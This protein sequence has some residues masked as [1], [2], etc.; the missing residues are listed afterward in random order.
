MNRPKPLVEFVKFPR[1]PHFTFSHKTDRDDLVLS[2]EASEKMFSLEVIVQEKTDGANIGLSFDREASLRIQNR[3]EYVDPKNSLFKKLGD[4]VKLHESQL[5]DV[6]E[7]DK[8]ILFGEWLYYQHS[9][10]YGNL[11]SFFLAHD[12]YDTETGLF[13]PTSA[14]HRAL[15]NTGIVTTPTIFKGKLNEPDDIIKLVGKS[16]FGEH[17]MEGVYVRI[18]GPHTNILRA[19]Y[20]NPEFRRDID[21]HWRNKNLRTNHAVDPTEALWTPPVD[22]TKS[23]D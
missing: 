5:F 7:G 15:N 11:P 17:K 12:I 20:V 18:D 22:Y 6:C 9:V 10:S 3:G 19:K 4:F 14:V 16:Q 23:N 1:T 21:E 8:K 13:L 2:P